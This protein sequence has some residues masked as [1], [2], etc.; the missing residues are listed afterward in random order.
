MDEGTLITE[1][2]VLDSTCEA[3]LGDVEALLLRGKGITCLKS[4]ANL[5]MPNLQVR[6]F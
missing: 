3:H 6:T 2:L 1:E 5:N 4:L